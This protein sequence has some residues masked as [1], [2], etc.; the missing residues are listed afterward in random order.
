V[1]RWKQIWIG[2]HLMMWGML[3]GEGVTELSP[4]VVE[5]WHFDQVGSTIPAG[6]IRVEG[7]Q[8]RES[9]VADIAGVLEQLTGVRVR[10]LT[11]NGNEGQ[12]ALRGFG[13]NSGLRV[14]VLV[15]GQVY[16]PPDM[17][18]INWTGLSLD[19]IEAVEVIRG[20]QGVMYGNHA[21]SGVVKLRTRDPARD[22]SG[23]LRINA[24]SDGARAF[25]GRIEGTFRGNGLR[26][27]VHLS[28]MD[29]YREH[30]ASEAQSTTLTWLFPASGAAR[31]RGRMQWSSQET[32]FPGPLLYSQ[33]RDNPRQSTSAGEDFSERDMIQATL[34]GAGEIGSGEWE[35]NAGV[36]ERQTDWT[37]DGAKGEN[38]HRR[39]SASPR[40]KTKIRNGFVISGIDV[41]GDRLRIRQ[42]LEASGRTG[43]G[44]GCPEKR[45]CGGIFPWK[46]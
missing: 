10:G 13:D 35:A 30:S 14:L 4:Y 44:T 9:G 8:I 17:S 41:H 11:G 21:V 34:H 23:A 20:G 19:E 42:F 15:D 43:E 31:W 12:L 45:D 5:A 27:G 46:L 22:L 1:R 38:H 26:G 16:N 32:Q 6:V 3:G 40:M 28:R 25:S 7:S 37:L 18:G 39:L 33:F 29:G 24:G 36:L 2:A